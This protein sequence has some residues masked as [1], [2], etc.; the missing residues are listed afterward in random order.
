MK[1]LIFVIAIVLAA[2]QAF[3][4]NLLPVNT[5]V[6]PADVVGSELNTASLITGAGYTVTGN[7]A[8]HIVTFNYG[9]GAR[10]QSDTTSP[11]L[12]LKPPIVMVVGRVYQVTV[13]LS[14][15]NVLKMSGLDS[16]EYV[17]NA[18]T[19]TKTGV[20]TATQLALLRNSAGVDVTVTAIS[21]KEVQWATGTKSF[22]NGTSFAQN[23]TGLTLSGDTAGVLS[24]ISGPGANGK[25][26]Q[27]ANTGSVDVV[28]TLT[29][30]KALTV[31][32]SY[33]PIVIAKRT[34]GSTA[35]TYKLTGGTA[36][37]IDSATFTPL[38]APAVA[39]NT[40][41][42]PIFTVP[43]G[44]TIQFYQPK[45]LDNA[46]GGFNFNAFDFGTY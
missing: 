23:I 21:I 27:I 19:Y 7:D 5:T 22:H 20:A 43:A 11:V 39:T 41:D 40:T 29:T 1:C 31:G 14:Q 45:L 8:T 37:N 44:V 15:A 12:N 28:V 38:A 16:A 26:Y 30:S 4:G 18:T 46:G 6:V 10:Y 9:G 33:R 2:G 35:A 3:G 25:A 42:K 36:V 34:V 32:R 24:I 13:A 17:L